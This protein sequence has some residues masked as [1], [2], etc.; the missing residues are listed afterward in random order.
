[1]ESIIRAQGI[2]PKWILTEINNKSL[3]K[4]GAEIL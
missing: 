1:M 4:V 3:N 2:I